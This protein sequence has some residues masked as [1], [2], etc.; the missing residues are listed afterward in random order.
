MTINYVVNV[1]Y[2]FYTIFMCYKQLQLNLQ[3]E[4]LTAV[5]I[6]ITVFW[7][8]H[9]VVQYVGTDVLEVLVAYICFAEEKLCNL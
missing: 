8:W 6:K 9:Y 3:S 1:V 4:V 2:Y 5:N 7:K